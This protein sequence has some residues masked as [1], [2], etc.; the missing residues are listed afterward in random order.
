M[1][2]I[3][4]LTLRAKLSVMLLLPL[5]GLLLFGIQGVSIKQDMSSRMAS[6][7]ELSGLAVRISAMVH[8]TQK[9]RGMTAGFLGSKGKKF[10]SE[11][12]KQRGL[13]DG[14][15]AELKRYLQGFDASAFSP[16]LNSN[17]TQANAQLE[18]ISRIRSSVDSL[19]IPLGK[20]LGY[21]TSMNGQYLNTIGTMTKLAPDAEMA[22]LT[23]GYVN[24]LLGK[25]RAGIERAVLTGTFARNNFAPGMFRKFGTLVTAQ[26]T[27]NT[28]FLSLATDAQKA[29]YNEKMS[30]SSVTQVQE[31]REVAFRKGIAS[32]KSD[33]LGTIYQEIG[34]GGAIHQFKNYVLRL[35]PQYAT[36]FMDRYTRLNKAM[37]RF[38]KLATAQEKQSIQTIRRVLDLY[39]AGIDKISPLI[40]AGKSTTELDQA[41]KVDD[42]PAINALIALSQST[43]SGQFGIDPNYW[44][45]TITSK[46]NLL[47]EVENRIADDLS[48]RTDE[49]N[50][51]AS[52]AFWAYLIFTTIVVLISV[53]IG[54]MITREIIRQLGGEPSDVMASTNRVA[55]GDLSEVFGVCM[56]TGICGSVQMMVGRLRSTV[57]TL[58][59]V[60]DN[61]ASQSQ[62]VGTS[63]NEVSEGAS[64]QAASIEQTSSA[65]EQMTSNIQ[66]NTEN[67]RATEKIALKASKDAKEGGDAVA[68]AVK[69]MKE[70]AEKIS[71]VEEIARQ[72]NLLALN[73]AIE[74]ARAGEHGKG[75]AVVAAEVRKLAERSQSA[76]GEITQLSS[77][78]V[79]VAERAGV[80]LSTLVPDIQ[81]T[82]EL[83]QEI[84]A[85]SEEQDQ[86]ASQ[87]NNAIQQ[88]DQVIQQNAGSAQEMASTASEL[89]QQAAEMQRT[90]SFFKLG[91]NHASESS[92]NRD[93]ALY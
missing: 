17:L 57:S 34:Y 66:Q 4:S 71:I 52:S 15:A 80:L 16:T 79:V 65:M 44:F 21:Y 46:I 36:G 6:M 14:R 67:A 45:K 73:A 58:I 53:G 85:G 50:G 1:G 54:M 24:F 35:S 43:A 83:I 23:A 84:A 87:I 31:M 51:A 82:A 64:N 39:K 47:K 61:I 19:S 38:D 18:Q 11:L 81:K 26:D 29:F 33:I 76:A 62:S 20:A 77:S 32:E 25:E 68:K 3:S 2:L 89:S 88:L 12:P 75:F 48:R 56:Q 91:D 5:A 8:E 93:I 72:T 86:G 90:I 69:A 55:N 30:A 42:T 37:D 9:E 78:S 27:Y 92:D 28:V 10:R 22:T 60:G 13:T 74:A 70:I 41:V 40:K 49:L 59:E 7:S 63:S